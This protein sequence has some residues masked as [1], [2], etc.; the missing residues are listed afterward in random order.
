MIRRIGFVLL[1]IAVVVL[2]PPALI[3]SAFE[4]RIVDDGQGVEGLVV[5]ADNGLSCR[6]QRGT[7]ACLWWASSLMGRRVHFAVRDET[8]QFETSEQR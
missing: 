2:G 3:G 5:P 8:N 6:T 4:L 1:I 7:G